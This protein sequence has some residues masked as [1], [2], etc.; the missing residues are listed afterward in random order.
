VV[1]R[2]ALA[3]RALSP[4][5]AGYG[6]AS[7]ARVTRLG[8]TGIV[9]DDVSVGD[10]DDPDLT[11][12]RVQLG[13][14][15]AGLVG[16]RAGRLEASGV[17]L[18][19]RWTDEGLSAG[20]LDGLLAPPPA[21][22]PA[23]GDAEGAPGVPFDSAWLRDVGVVIG[24][25]AGA[26]RAEGQLRLESPG[27]K[28]RVRVRARLE[29]PWGP[30]RVLAEL[31]APRWRAK[32]AAR[33]LAPQEAVRVEVARLAA[34]GAGEVLAGRFD[35]ARVVST[36]DPP[37]FGP[38]ALDGTANGTLDRLQ[39]ESVVRAEGDP[40]RATLSGPVEPRLARAR[41]TF[42]LPETSLEGVRV[43][44]VLPAL[45]DVIKEIRGLAGA[46]GT[47]AYDDKGLRADADLGVRDAELS[48]ELVT[49]RGVNAAVS[50]R[51]SP[52]LT[53]PP[54]QMVSMAVVDGP[55]PL[56]DGLVVFRLAPDALFLERAEWRLAEGTL[57]ASG[58][59]LL[60]ARDRTV[61]LTADGVDLQALLAS[62]A[63]EG[64]SGTGTL[65]GR[66]PIRQREGRFAIEAGRLAATAPGTLRYEA[67]PGTEAMRRRHREMDVLLVALEDFHYDELELAIA[68]DLA[69]PM[70]MTLR[71]RGR[72]PRY[73]GG[74][75]VVLNVNVEAPL[76]GL[77]RS[78]GSAYRVPAAIQKRLQSMGLEG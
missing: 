3:Q 73:E 25:S 66:L 69:E 49:L 48:L 58:R 74:R 15:L 33:S 6:I 19:A 70:T 56:H 5:L 7:S 16:R 12:E 57:R 47:I 10:R 39:V 51:L 72:N 30:A 2:R 67:S 32:L 18:R 76:A 27:A 37:W 50:A 4:R 9:F 77:V 41:L 65:E 20:A 28:P 63:I 60:A 53:T 14:S 55:L 54:G 71:I 24:H 29:T 1:Q 40:V 59:V 38:V 61:T 45:G 23:A 8:L 36:A 31:R 11:A 42:D 52:A 22:E 75:A 46:K 21:R 17:R 26:F 62:L 44:R 43:A 68:G 78:G 34:R 64:L 35:V 13:W